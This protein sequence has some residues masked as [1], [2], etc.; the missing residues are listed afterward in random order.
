MPFFAN[1]NTEVLNPLKSFLNLYPSPFLQDLFFLLRLFLMGFLTFLFLRELSLSNLSSLFGAV[2]FMLSGYSLWWINLHPLSSALYI[3]GLFYL[4]E[5]IAPGRNRERKGPMDNRKGT[6]FPGWPSLLFP[7]LLASSI[8]A[9]KMPVVIMGLMLL[10]IWALYKNIIRNAEIR[11][12]SENAVPST[13][14]EKRSLRIGIFR[15]AVQVIPLNLILLITWGVFMASA[16]IVP[17]LEL[18]N[19]SSLIAGAARTGASSHTLPIISSI[20]LWQ[21]LFLGMKN[22]FYGSWLQW[23]PRSMMPYAGI[24][25]LFLTLYSLTNR[26]VLARVLP[27]SLFSL[28]LF[29]KIYGI[30][31]GDVLTGIPL[32]GS[33]NFIK[34]HGMFY[35]SLAFVSAH[36]LEDMKTHHSRHFYV[37]LALTASVVLPWSM[38]S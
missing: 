6:A 8:F 37:A 1:P 9:G 3:P 16:V 12:Q 36:A 21:P 30:I 33:M 23:T 28:F 18:L 35:F 10:F 2:F 19:H 24:T 11:A 27:F 4:Y 13:E 15:G 26:R 34:Y 38:P 5:K 20:T 29:L 22:Y 25:A 14:N 17:F 31:P 7:L 32:L